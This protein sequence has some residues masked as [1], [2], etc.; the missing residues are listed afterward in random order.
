[1]HISKRDAEAEAI[2]LSQEF[3]ARELSEATRLRYSLW[4]VHPELHEPGSRDRKT[5]IRY[6]VIFR[7]TAPDE[8]AWDGGEAMIRVDIK[9]R[10]SRWWP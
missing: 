4:R 10:E 5:I 8:Q 7:R 2:R 3:L 9:T 1:M 6:T